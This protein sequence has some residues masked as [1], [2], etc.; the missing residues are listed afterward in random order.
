MSETHITYLAMSSIYDGVVLPGDDAC[1]TLNDIY[2]RIDGMEESDEKDALIAAI[3]MILSVF[4]GPGL[5]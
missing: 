5:G 3:T 2:Q 4:C 1:Q